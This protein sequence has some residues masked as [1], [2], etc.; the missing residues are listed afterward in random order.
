MRWI[1]DA[2]T[3]VVLVGSTVVSAAAVGLLAIVVRAGSWD[4]WLWVVLAPLLHLVWLLVFLLLNAG[5]CRA[6]GRR[7]PKPRHAMLLPGPLRDSKNVGGLLTANA[8]YRRYVILSRLP[9]V[10]LISQFR[11]L[12]GLVFRAY[13]PSVH[14]GRNVLCLGV[15]FDP[16]LTE[17]GDNVVLGDRSMVVAHSAVIRPDGGLVYVSAPV[18][19]GN[20][21]T[22]GGDARVALGCV[23]G[24]DAIVEPGAILEPFTRI[25]AGEVWAGSPAKLRRRREE[26]ERGQRA[27]PAPVE[28]GAPGV[29]DA[30]TRDRA[31]RLVVDALGLSADEA[32]GELDTRTCPAW[33]SLG[34]VAVAAALFDRFGI[35]VE[36]PDVFGI[37]SV[38]DIVAL[39][40]GPGRAGSAAAAAEAPGS[41]PRDPSPEEAWPGDDVEM[42]PLL[43]AQAATRAL[44]ESL[45]GRPG[46]GTPLRVNVVA[47]FTAQPIESALRLWGRAFGYELDCRF[48]GYDQ[49]VQTLLEPGELAGASGPEMTVVLTRPEDFPA[50]RSAAGDKLEELLDAVEQ[51]AARRLPDSRLLVGTLPPV[52]S[53]LGAVDRGLSDELRDRWRTR[54]AAMGRVEVF[55]F[56][57]VVERVGVE[58]ARSSRLEVHARAAYSARLHQELAIAL[59]RSIRAARGRRAKV[60]ALDCDNTLWGGVV[61]EVGLEGLQLGP[62][63]PG[64]SFQLFQQYLLRLKERGLLLAVVSKNEEPD[65]RDVFTR[66][67]GMVL[68]VDDIAAWRVNW[69]HKSENLRELADE[70][71]LGLDS[72]VLVDD[73]PAVRM[74]VTTRVPEV[75]VVPLPDDPAAFCETLDRLWLFDGGAEITVEDATRT[76]KAQQEERRSRERGAASSLED[77]LTRLELEVELDRAGESDWPRVA[78]LT[79]RTNQ[80]NLSLRRRTHEEV[81]ALDSIVLTVRAR[82]RFGDYGQVGVCVLRPTAQ[83]GCW[84]IET[85]LMSCRALGRGIEDAFLHGIA[86]TAAG[87][88]ASTLVAPFVRGPRNELV[89]TFLA[90]VG[91]DETEPDVWTLPIEPLPPLPGH[92]RF[93]DS[94][95]VAVPGDDER[96]V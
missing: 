93:Y 24:D 23:I 35:A 66:H 29:A 78:Q 68:G 62:D 8:C 28:A 60:V 50:E 22:I 92:V 40:T 81:R 55:D 47:S 76:E 69:Q 44:A 67:P 91:F 38:D 2:L 90:R 4:W 48:A 7:N 87:N 79:Q 1:Q 75:H 72:F 57:H 27:E 14:M 84:E 13:S 42:L 82:D 77:F 61:G 71:N 63:G 21:V 37:T 80:F 31:R 15:V 85:L 12:N 64:R 89:R 52:V 34:Q 53:S 46:D 36:G 18:S 26:L 5:I 30:D 33:D 95:A 41:V 56:A 32:E 3:A 19:I 51:A 73:D 45:D 10:S 6:M 83:P 65:V 96:A 54:L 70:L 43:D 86:A 11:T 25:P 88:G 74:E 58:G 20:R 16:D 39:V 17:I 9:F 49:I 94:R 59:V